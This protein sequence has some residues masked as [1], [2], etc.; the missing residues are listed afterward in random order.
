[1]G[2]LI[3]PGSA[4]VFLRYLIYGTGFITILNAAVTE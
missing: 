3:L 4:L 1:M 2:L